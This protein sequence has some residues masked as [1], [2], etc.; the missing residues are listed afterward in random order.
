MNSSE[1]SGRRERGSQTALLLVA[2]CAAVV[3]VYLPALRLGPVAEDLQWALKGA[4][5]PLHPGSLLEPFHQHVR[6]AG[7]LFFAAAVALFGQ[8]WV[9]YRV[10]Q[11]ALLLV[12]TVLAWRLLYRT[13][14]L[15]PL[16]V[17]LVVA[18]WLI[19]PLCDD[20]M[21][22]TNQVKQVLLAL[23]VVGVLLLREGPRAP[24][25]QLGT[26]AFAVLAAAAKEEWVVL[27]A[28]VLAQD[29][30]LLRVTLR[31][32]LRR[33][34]PWACAVVAYLAAYWV[35][36]H[37]QA[38]WFYGQ[39]SSV[40]LAKGVATL[41]A[42]FHVLPPVPWEF[43]SLL[44]E[45]PLGASLS[46]ALMLVLLVFTV[47]RRERRALFCLVASA[48]TALPTLPGAAQAGRYLLLPWF[49]FLVACAL[50]LREFGRTVRMNRQL[51]VAFVVL[52][53][54]LL[55]GDAVR[56]RADC[57]DWARFAA[58]ARAVE[59]EAAPLVQSAREGSALV[60]FRG[61]DGGPLRRLLESPRGQLKLYFPR[62]DDPYGAVSLS[63][64][65]SWRTYREGFVLERVT[66]LPPGQAVAGFIHETGFFQAHG[67]PRGPMIGGG[68]R[69]P[70]ILLR[71]PW[72]TFDPTVFP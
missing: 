15:P 18:L 30:L 44:A 54:V 43:R 17:A 10:V 28:L 42:F 53:V 22:I 7:N 21:F 40:V 65:L 25:R 64:L 69:P 56:V 38:R 46:V 5:T 4:T 50:S 32:A 66:T 51:D 1:T 9:A 36:V 47:V 55:A 23:G 71:R 41:G 72:A 33:A 63:A 27:P 13:L 26:A 49:F 16:G 67:T 52:G 34:V 6:P 39:G 62:P 12:L 24:A 61:D 8:Q 14:A 57:I 3:L 35:L 60:V 70:L 37:F 68:M 58:I 48:L 45:R 29:L 19:S 31:R 11:L 20:V 59:A 2:V